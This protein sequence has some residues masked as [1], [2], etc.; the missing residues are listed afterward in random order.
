MNGLHLCNMLMEM[1]MFIKWPGKGHG[2]HIN[3]KPQEGSA[4]SEVLLP[5]VF[6]DAG[7]GAVG[8]RVSSR[9]TKNDVSCQY[10]GH[11]RQQEA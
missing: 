9:E 3:F 1:E 8:P 5:F 10:G 2:L 4:E 6:I 11:D 7:G